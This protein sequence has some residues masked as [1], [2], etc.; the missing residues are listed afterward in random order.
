MVIFLQSNTKKEYF[1]I[2]G[3]RITKSQKSEIAILQSLSFYVLLVSCMHFHFIV[4]LLWTRK[5]KPLLGPKSRV[6]TSQ[7]RQQLKNIRSYVSEIFSEDS[8]FNL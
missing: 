5:Q 7:R 1:E 3:V 4:C 8:P 2:F 6:V